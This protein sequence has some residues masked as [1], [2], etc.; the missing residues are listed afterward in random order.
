M[1]ITI[2]FSNQEINHIFTLVL[3]VRIFTK[4]I[5]H[6]TF[7]QINQSYI[8]HVNHTYMFMPWIMPFS[9]KN[10]NTNQTKRFKPTKSDS[11]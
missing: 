7:F 4:A 10:A 11:L 2:S 9:S 3:K 5:K 1:H 8:I 6:G